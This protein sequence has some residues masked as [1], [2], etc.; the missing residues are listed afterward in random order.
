MLRASR[1]S[2][3]RQPA[4]SS[5]RAPLQGGGTVLPVS[6]LSWVPQDGKGLRGVVLRSHDQKPIFMGFLVIFYVIFYGIS[7][8]FYG[9]LMV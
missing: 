2:L 1:A 6:L 9:D 5:P 4:L 7:R 3:T 8:D